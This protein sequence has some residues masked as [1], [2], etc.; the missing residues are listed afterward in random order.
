MSHISH[1]DLKKQGLKLNKWEALELQSHINR[2][3]QHGADEAEEVYAPKEEADFEEEES[4]INDGPVKKEHPKTKAKRLKDA[5]LFEHT[6]TQE[7]LENNPELAEN[8]VK[9]GNVIEV[10]IK[11]DE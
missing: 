5:G 4:K 7:D 6:V 2:I 8:G 10:P 11:E 1:D 9:E 3:S